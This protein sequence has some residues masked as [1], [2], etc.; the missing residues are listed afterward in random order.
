MSE[1]AKKVTAI[2]V[3]KLGVDEAEVTREASF[4]NQYRYSR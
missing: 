3:D 4:T 2:I 1:I